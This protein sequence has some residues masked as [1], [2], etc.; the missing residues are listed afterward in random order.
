[1]NRTYFSLFLFLG[2]AGCK[3]S[4]QDF[5]AS[6]VF[7]A[8]EV[9][10]SSESVGK[11]LRFDVEEGSELKAGQVI[12]CMGWPLGHQ[13]GGGF[14]Y[15]FSEHELAVGLILQLDYQNPALDPFAL[16]RQ[17]KSHPSVAA[18]LEGAECQGF[19]ARTLSEGGWQSLGKLIFP[20]GAFI[21]CAAGL[22]DLLHQQGIPHAI[23]SGVLAAQACVNAITNRDDSKLLSEYERAVKTGEIADALQ[24]ARA[25]KPALS[26]FMSVYRQK[27]ELF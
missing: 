9:I 21:G 11:I 26:L 14:L 27:R 1:M 22:L 16:F 8:N 23:Q 13:A 20:G 18:L 7:E 10:I 6:G 25:I 3:S 17:F 12:H 24:Q 5:D 15:A 4:D 19:G 2:L